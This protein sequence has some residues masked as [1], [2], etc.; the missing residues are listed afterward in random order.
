M[1]KAIRFYRPGG[2]EV[3][4]WEEVPVGK[5]GPLEARGIPVHSVSSLDLPAGNTG[6]PESGQSPLQLRRPAQRSV[7]D[8]QQET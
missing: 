3:L 2:P 8:L 5:P 4:V 1:P 7:R 6:V